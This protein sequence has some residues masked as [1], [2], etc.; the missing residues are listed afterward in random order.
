MTQNQ[1]KKVGSVENCPLYCVGRSGSIPQAVDYTFYSR[2]I[3]LY[4]VIWI[5]LF[6]DGLEYEDYMLSY[7][8]SSGLGGY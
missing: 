8:G 3:A 2:R 5:I 1:D 6:L 7:Y 4:L